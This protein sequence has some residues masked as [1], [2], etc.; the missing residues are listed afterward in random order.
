MKK[1]RECVQ[2]TEPF[3]KACKIL[4][5]D[6]I[7][8]DGWAHLFLRQP[9]EGEESDERYQER[10]IATERTLRRLGRSEL[11][12]LAFGEGKR[13]RWCLPAGAA[14]DPDADLLG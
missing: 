4:Y 7:P 1:I 12:R 6:F 2:R 5:A 13:L 10:L 11:K 9:Q 14:I 3:Q 8:T